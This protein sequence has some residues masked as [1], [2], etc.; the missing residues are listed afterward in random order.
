ME[1]GIHGGGLGTNSPAGDNYAQYC[2]SPG[3]GRRA[4]G[5]LAAAANEPTLN[6]EDHMLI[7][8]PDCKQ[9]TRIPH[10]ADFEAWKRRSLYDPR[11]AVP[12]EGCG[13][14]VNL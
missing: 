5:R 6:G 1:R 7:T 8:I 2:A 10:G 9:I 14:P 13:K 3:A 11:V 12:I 4:L